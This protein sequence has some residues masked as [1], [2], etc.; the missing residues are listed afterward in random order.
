MK[1]VLLISVKI[2]LGLILFFSSSVFVVIL[3]LGIW[4]INQDDY[5]R[6]EQK[7]KFT[8]TTSLSK[9]KKPIEQKSTIKLNLKDETS[10]S[11]A[12][13]RVADERIISKEDGKIFQG[14]KYLDFVDKVQAE[15]DTKQLNH[16]CEIICDNS[17]FDR[18]RLVADP[19]VY[20]ENFYLQNKNRAYEDFYFRHNLESA[21]V[22]AIIINPGIRDLYMQS[23]SIEQKSLYEQT[24]FL[25]KFQYMLAYSIYSIDQI[26]KK[27]KNH[28]KKMSDLR[29]LRK[30]C[31]Y[32]SA[33]AAQRS[34]YQILDTVEQVNQ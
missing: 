18:E 24:L 23:L 28:E 32:T 21:K 29:E 17:S 25:A 30:T 6:I 7:S 14:L 12:V 11:D 31:D 16:I 22:I 26:G 34:C 2:I 13:L 33:K 19:Y 10:S 20:L 9:D 1:N 15:M 8:N 5:R 4:F 27:F 3:V